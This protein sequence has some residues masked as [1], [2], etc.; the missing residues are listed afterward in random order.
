[1]SILSD[2]RA[3]FAQ[4]AGGKQVGHGIW[5]VSFMDYDLGSTDLEGKTMQPIENRFGP[6]V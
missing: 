1:M 3:P 4:A 2:Y 5:L 6:K